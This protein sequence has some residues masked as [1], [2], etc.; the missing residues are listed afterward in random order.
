MAYR[1][2]SGISSRFS[3]FVIL[4]TGY[5]TVAGQLIRADF[6]IPKALTIERNQLQHPVIIQFH[7]GAL[8]SDFPNQI[9]LM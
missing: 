7:S 4:Q 1:D 8:V 3:N 2:G 9:D 6:L 5:K